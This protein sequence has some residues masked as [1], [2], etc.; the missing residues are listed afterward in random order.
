[1]IFYEFFFF[2]YF[3]FFKIFVCNYYLFIFIFYWKFFDACLKTSLPTPNDKKSKIRKKNPFQKSKFYL[4]ISSPE[5][6]NR[7]I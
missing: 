1:M 7:Q 2:H 5:T 6:P 4:K 3:S